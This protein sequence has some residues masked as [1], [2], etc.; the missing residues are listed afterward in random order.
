M[1]LRLG[2]MEPGGAEQVRSG[3]AMPDV[4]G[5]L[6]TLADEFSVESEADGDYL[7][8]GFSSPAPAP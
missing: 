1:R 7:A 2:P 4:G 8:I 6:E 3:L 5:S